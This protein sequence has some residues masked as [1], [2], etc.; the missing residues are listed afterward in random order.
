MSKESKDSENGAG[1]LSEFLRRQGGDGWRPVS[2]TERVSVIQEFSGREPIRHMANEIVRLRKMNEELRSV[3]P[4]DHPYREVS[5]P[6][7]GGG[8]RVGVSYDDLTGQT[9]TILHEIDHLL[10]ET[11]D[12]Y[13]L[14][15]KGSVGIL[16]LHLAK[17]AEK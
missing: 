11:E 12:G 13:V 15:P 3:G 14:I 9:T 2:F 16:T 7:P 6:R 4:V 10:I 1:Q 8:E 5:Y 17:M